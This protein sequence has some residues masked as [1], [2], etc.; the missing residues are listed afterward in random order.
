MCIRDRHE[1]VHSLDMRASYDAQRN[2]FCA[3]VLGEAETP[4][5][6]LLGNFKAYA[7]STACLLYTSRCV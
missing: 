4:Y 2:E 3:Y 1:G 6:L 5:G 7:Q